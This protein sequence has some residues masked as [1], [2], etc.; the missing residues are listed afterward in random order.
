MAF[1]GFGRS[2]V[3]GRQA[4]LGIRRKSTSSGADTTSSSGRLHVSEQCAAAPPFVCSSG[5]ALTNPDLLS[6]QPVLQAGL[7]SGSMSIIGDML[8]QR[9]TGAPRKH[10][11]PTVYFGILAEALLMDVR[12]WCFIPD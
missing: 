9:I 6:L 1:P 3:L 11:P 5:S 4:L 7:I 12:T 2:L 8:A 10:L